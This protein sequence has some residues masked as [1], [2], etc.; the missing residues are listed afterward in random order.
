MT[1]NAEIDMNAMVD[2]K[3]LAKELA[4]LRSE[5][6]DLSDKVEDFVGDAEADLVNGAQRIGR[7]A[8]KAAGRDATYVLDE[9]EHNPVTA[10]S[11]ALAIGALVGIFFTVRSR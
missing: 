8:W 7:R 1:V 5:L 3:A 4:Q 2:V 11:V 9:I 10:V 6:A